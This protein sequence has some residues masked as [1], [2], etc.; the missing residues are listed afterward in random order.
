ME[1]VETVEI[2]GGCFC[3]EIRYRSTARPVHQTVCHCANCRRAA[4]AQSVA[5]VTF[6]VGSFAY[7]QGEPA[8]YRAEN[9]AVWSFCGRCGTT[10]TYQHDHR[11]DEIDV[12]TGSLD[13]PEAFP[14]TR[15]VNLDEK[16]SWA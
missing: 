3:G 6:Q 10:L 2:P 9:G 7:R 5:W 15:G 12:T 8:R 1:T 13:D 14:P 11:P 4:G 16:L